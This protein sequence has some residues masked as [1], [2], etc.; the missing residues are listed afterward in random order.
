MTADIAVANT[1]MC[2]VVVVDIF[3]DA[4]V[5]IEDIMNYN[6]LLCILSMDKEPTIMYILQRMC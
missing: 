6:M 4:T 5:E 2:R 1:W 3:G